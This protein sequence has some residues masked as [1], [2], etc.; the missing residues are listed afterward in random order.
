V[1]TEVPVAPMNVGYAKQAFDEE[2]EDRLW[3][4]M[5]VDEAD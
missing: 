3:V 1:V 4:E 5:V 2:V